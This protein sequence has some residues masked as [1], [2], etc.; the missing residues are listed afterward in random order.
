MEELTLLF[1][2]L[3][4]TQQPSEYWKPGQTYGIAMKTPLAKT[5]L[6]HLETWLRTQPEAMEAMF[7]PH[8][9][10]PA[11][12]LSVTQ[13]PRWS[14]TLSLTAATYPPIALGDWYRSLTDC[15]IGSEFNLSEYHAVLAA[16][17]GTA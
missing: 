13:R 15:W 4:T 2:H 14:L 5:L 9:A 11:L 10:G 17:K 7:T 8:G 1:G 16:L 3:Y 6:G 12:Q